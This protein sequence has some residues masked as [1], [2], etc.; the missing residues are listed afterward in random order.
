[1]LVW[2]TFD[3]LQGV[4]ESY[5]GCL[6]LLLPHATFVQLNSKKKEKSSHVS[7]KRRPSDC[8]DGGGAEKSPIPKAFSWTFNSSLLSQ[9]CSVISG[10]HFYFTVFT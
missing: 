10:R 6:S 1:M 9:D 4:G 2:L 3:Y 7:R 8:G 5:S